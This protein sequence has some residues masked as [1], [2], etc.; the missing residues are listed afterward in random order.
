MFSSSDWW[1]TCQRCA[2]GDVVGGIRSIISHIYS[3]IFWSNLEYRKKLFYLYYCW[4]Y[5]YFFTP[6]LSTVPS[7]EY[8]YYI[9]SH[10]FKTYFFFWRRCKIRRY[11]ELWG[12]Q[13]QASQ[14]KCSFRRVGL[15]LRFG[16]NARDVRPSV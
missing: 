10:Y 7:R 5:E 13:K 3:Q 4:S 9:L 14:A 2:A 1:A 6:F 11:M 12:G 15:P 16:K 8:E